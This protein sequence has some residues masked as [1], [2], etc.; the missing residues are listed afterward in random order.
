M[1][2]LKGVIFVVVLSL[3]LLILVYVDG[4]FQGVIKGGILVYICDVKYNKFFWCNQYKLVR[5]MCEVV[6]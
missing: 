6:L 3:Y 1:K 2:K 4:G 5:K